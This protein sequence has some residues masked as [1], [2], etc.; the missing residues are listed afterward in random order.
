MPINKGA[1]L[2]AFSAIAAFWILGRFAWE[3]VSPAAELPPVSVPVAETNERSRQSG[4]TEPAIVPLPFLPRHLTRTVASFKSENHT[5]QRAGSNLKAKLS[6][7]EPSNFLAERFPLPLKRNEQAK[8]LALVKHMFV[9]PPE[10]TLEPKRDASRAPSSKP[11]SGYF[12]TFVRQSSGSSDLQSMAPTLQSLGGQYGGSQA[13]AILTYRLTGNQQLGLSAFVRASTALSSTGEE[14]L[15]VGMKVTPLPRIPIS[16][17]AEQRIGA[18]GFRN[19]GTAFYVAGGTGPDQL[20]FGTN[21]ETYGQAGYIFSDDNSY[22]FD[23]SASLHREILER[24]K[25]KITA[26]AGFWAGGQEGLTRLDIGPR[27]NIHVPVGEMNM[28]FSIDW[29]QRVGGN[30]V[31]D[32][33]VAVTATTGF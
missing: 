2:W 23:A 3:A 12:W 4:A 16:L 30:A 24:G 25:Y 9:T 31:P 26:G 17:F 32:S 28:R 14:E 21:L 29:R 13:G 19:R 6:E 18:K 10:R 27:A 22:F 8:P 11:L 33:G 15:A 5:I 20:L 1:P 7:T